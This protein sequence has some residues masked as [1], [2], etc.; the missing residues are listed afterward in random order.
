M[1]KAIAAVLAFTMCISLCSCVDKNSPDYRYDRAVKLMNSGKYAEAVTEFDSL[2]GYKDSADLSRK[3]NAKSLNTGKVKAGDII[4]FGDYKGHTNWRVLTVNG[5]EAYITTVDSVD[6]YPFDASWCGW[7]AKDCDIKIWLN[8][9]YM[10]AAFTDY[11]KEIIVEKEG[12]KVFL[13]SIEEAY[14]Y[15]KDN[16]DR[17]IPINDEL[18][19][20]LRSKGIYADHAAFII[21]G[22]VGKGGI[23]EYGGQ[24]F[25]NRGVRPALWIK[26][27][28]MNSGATDA[29]ETITESGY[30]RFRK[31]GSE[32][33]LIGLTKE[34][35]RQEELVI[36]AGVKIF[37]NVVDGLTNQCLKSV[38]FESDDDVD[39]GYL[40]AGSQT[41]E[42]VKLPAKLT[43][44]GMHSNAPKLREIV[45]PEGVRKIPF[46]C[47]CNDRNLEKVEIKGNLTEIDELAFDGCISLKNLKLPDSVTSIG[48]VAFQNCRSLGEI[49][50]PKGL[51]NMGEYVFAY[52]DKIT[53]TVPEE[54]QLEK[55]DRA[56]SQPESEDVVPEL[57][58]TV[59]VKK[60]SW[61]D[62]HFEEV[63]TASAVKEYF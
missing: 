12:L 3:A 19:Y 47:F 18:G 37:G 20:W 9:K 1:K 42:R 36:P 29:T 27:D 49:T 8:D 62:L 24:V 21:S 5:S 33:E 11:E 14:R 51:K 25:W 46:S 41:L 26:T 48:A 43:K 45:I 22:P 57:K 56:F 58:L 38:V 23:F 54:M 39:Y 50:L 13:L 32:T 34:G 53:V 35:F 30:F 31:T 10:N 55:W 40:M 17:V 28:S 63:F 52:C 44:L 59:R 7:D 61:A 2:N 6:S 16:E 15:F 60:G 4:R